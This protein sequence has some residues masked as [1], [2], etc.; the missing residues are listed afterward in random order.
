MNDGQVH[1]NAHATYEYQYQPTKLA[2]YMMGTALVG[3]FVL[4]GS[5]SLVQQKDDD[6][7]GDNPHVLCVLDAARP[8]CASM[9]RHDSC[10]SC[11]GI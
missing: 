5:V 4:I 6:L 9:C 3:Y 8:A 10:S 2:Q 1:D 7:L 11:I